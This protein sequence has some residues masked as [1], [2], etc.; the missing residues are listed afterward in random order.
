CWEMIPVHKLSCPECGTGLS[1]IDIIDK[2]SIRYACP[3]CG[4]YERIDT[5]TPPSPGR[6]ISEQL[7]VISNLLSQ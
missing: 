3:G 2:V 1:K 6:V 7:T 5:D 4:K